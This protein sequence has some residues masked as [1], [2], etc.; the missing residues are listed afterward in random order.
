MMAGQRRRGWHAL[1]EFHSTL[2]LEFESAHAGEGYKALKIGGL[3][4]GLTHSMF[5]LGCGEDGKTKKNVIK[6]HR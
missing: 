1:E 3:G 4:F 2:D 5:Q 6:I